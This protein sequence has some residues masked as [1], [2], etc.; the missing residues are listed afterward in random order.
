MNV[1]PEKQNSNFNMCEIA[2]E[3]PRIRWVQLYDYNQGI[4]YDS[5]HAIHD[6]PTFAHMLHEIMLG[7]PDNCDSWQKDL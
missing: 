6:M 5:L 1:L 4:T 7:E 3:I 2:S